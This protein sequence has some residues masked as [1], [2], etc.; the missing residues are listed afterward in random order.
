[1]SNILGFTAWFHD[2]SACLLRDGQ[3]VAF[4]EEERFSRRKH[5]P[6]YPRRS[7]EYC[8]AEGGLTLDELDAVVFYMD[9]RTMIRNN[10]W[11]LLRFFP[12]SLNLFRKSTTVVPIRERYRNL[13]NIKP[14]LCREHGAVGRFPLVTLPHYRTHQGAA[15]LCSP[16]DDAA[17]ITM[18][19]AVDGTT[20]TIAHGK[21]NRIETVLKHTLP[22]GW[23]MLYCAFTRYVG[24]KFYDEYKVM[25]MAAYGRPRYLDFIEER[26]YRFDDETGEFQLNLD[27]FAYQYHGMRRLWND[28]LTRELGPARDP[29]RPLEQRDYDLAASIQAA[30]ERFGVRMARLARRLTGARNLTMAGGVVQNCLMNQKIIEAGL[31]DQ[32]FLQPLASDVGCSLGGALYHYHCTLGRPRSFVMNHLYWGPDYKDDY[33]TALQERGLVF[34]QVESPAAE[35]ARAIAEGMIVGFVCGRMEAGPRALG[36]RSILADPRRHD[37]KDIL[38][39][40][41]KHREHFRPFA[42]SCLE[43]RMDE[44][45]EPLPGCRSLGYM[46][47]T[48]TV[49]PE[50]RPRVP[51]ITHNDGTARPQAVSR[52]T[53]PLYWEIIHEFDKLTGVPVVVNTSFNDNEPIVCTPQDAI[54]C[55]LRT[56]IDLLV[57]E[58][59]LVY[60]K[61]NEHIIAAAR[62]RVGVSAGGAGRDVAA[63]VAP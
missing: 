34:K 7:I 19:V 57:L 14:I 47:T 9:P 20:Q 36:A 11:Y 18:D 12:W 8:L 38:N 46:I 51:T 42:P 55:F 63:G 6:E 30:T 48:A 13:L 27:Y 61:D 35:I 28:R 24:F 31:F 41:V 5:T 39:L 52:A 21:G 60:R 25:G 43:E 56:R 37:M 45:F 1:M 44:V 26:L 33:R 16:F 53:S 50:M 54:N 4:A 49:R 10:L 59:Y 62:E 23:G 22:H 58:N 2:S 17:I 40:R 29:S 3:L 15:F 32:V